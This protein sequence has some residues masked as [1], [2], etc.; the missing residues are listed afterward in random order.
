MKKGLTLS[1]LVLLLLTAGYQFSQ[2]GAEE[3]LKNRYMNLPVDWHAK[4]ALVKLD[5]AIVEAERGGNQ[6]KLKMLRQGRQSLSTAIARYG[7]YIGNPTQMTRPVDPAASPLGLLTHLWRTKEEMIQHRAA[8]ERSPTAPDVS[9]EEIKALD[10]AINEAIDAMHKAVDAV[11]SARGWTVHSDG[12]FLSIQTPPGFKAT[13]NS[14]FR[15]CLTWIPPGGKEV[16]KALFVSVRPN[17]DKLQP[18]EHQPQAIT[19]ERGEHSDLEVIEERRGYLGVSG[20]WF[21]YS[22][23]WQ[24]K[25]LIGQIHHYT[26]SYYVWE[27]KYLAVASKF[28]E[29]EGEGII[30]SVQRK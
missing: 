8:S 29:E 21:S 13:K 28:D 7:E 12:M 23:T 25:K 2:S 5:R 22:Y 16:E 10:K 19:R 24:N 1:M 20:M 9:L 18:Y 17:K 6:D 27:I 3:D 14:N 26:D 11:E 15:L 30:R 4:C